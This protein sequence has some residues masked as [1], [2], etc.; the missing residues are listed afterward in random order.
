MIAGEDDITLFRALVEC[1]IELV[2]SIKVLLAASL[3][4]EATEIGQ[5]LED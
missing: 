1:V 2:I 4:H 5:A 3:G